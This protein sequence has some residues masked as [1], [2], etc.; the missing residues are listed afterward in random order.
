MSQVDLQVLDLSH[1]DI[2]N[3]GAYY[4]KNVMGTLVHLNLSTTK[5]GLKGISELSKAIG[6]EESPR[7]K[8]LD[9]TMNNIESEGFSKVLLKLKSLTKLTTLLVSDNDMSLYHEFFDSLTQ[10]LKQNTSLTTLQMNHCGLS[11]KAIMYL[12]R[13]LK[14]NKTLQHLSLGQNNFIEH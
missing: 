13:G 3:E 10:F 11:N 14:C 1:N 8:H 5:I 12:S 9:L 7:L 2:G 4:L 6:A